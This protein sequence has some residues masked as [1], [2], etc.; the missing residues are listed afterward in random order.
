MHDFFSFSH[1]LNLN[2]DQNLLMKLVNA[3]YGCTKV[4]DAAWSYSVGNPEFFLGA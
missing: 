2:I 4:V 1:G 3:V